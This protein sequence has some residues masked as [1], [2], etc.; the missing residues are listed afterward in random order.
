VLGCRRPVVS[1]GLP[2]RHTLLGRPRCSAPK[3]RSRN[4]SAPSDIISTASRDTV[5]KLRLGGAPTPRSWVVR[6]TKRPPPHRCRQERLPN[7]A[8]SP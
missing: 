8:S 7:E 1:H 4:L 5:A 2:L 6:M 3:T